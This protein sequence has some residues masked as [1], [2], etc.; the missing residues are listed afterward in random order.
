[1][2]TSSSIRRHKKKA[3]E[4]STH[5]SLIV[6]GQNFRTLNMQKRSTVEKS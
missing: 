6:I 3:D 5:L 2:E 4:N 1:M